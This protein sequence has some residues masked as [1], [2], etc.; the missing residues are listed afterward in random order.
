MSLN[1]S[2]I[3]AFFPPEQLPFLARLKR[4]VAKTRPYAGLKILH[5]IPLTMETLPKID[6]LL[7]GGAEL[8]VTSSTFMTPNP[9]AAAVLRAADVTLQIEHDFEDDFDICMDCCGE[10]LDQV[11]PRI[12]MVELT[13][14]GSLRY[15][16]RSDLSYPVISVDESAVKNL[17]TL[18]GTG[19]GFL[20]AFR[21]LTGECVADKAFLLFGYGKVGQGIAHALSRYTRDIAVVEL[22]A[23]LLKKAAADGYG[24]IAGGDK[25]AVENAAASAFAVVTATGQKGVVSASYDSKAIKKAAYLANMGGEDEFGEA[26]TTDEVLV[27]KL[28]I[29]FA[30]PQPTLIRYLDPVFY[31]HNLAIE[32]LRAGELRAGVYSFPDHVAEAIVE[33]WLSIFGT[34]GDAMVARKALSG[35]L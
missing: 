3:H 6:V 25:R 32:L 30:I 34:G 18:L 10:L 21:E 11:T 27:D 23:G 13:K 28:P 20:R 1:A 8:T 2:Q 22:D 26:F 14:T 4:R 24:P 31:A 35:T 9:T 7:Q 19:D 16:A 33:E 15:R 12:G 5:N 17:E 29:N